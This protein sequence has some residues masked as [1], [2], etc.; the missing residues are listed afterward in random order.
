MGRSGDC[1][2]FTGIMNDTC[3]AGV[4]YRELVGPPETGWAARL[5]C[6]PNSSL[7]KPPLVECGKFDPMTAEE[8]RAEKKEF[9]ERFDL[10]SR[11]ITAIKKLGTAS[12]T[13]VCPKCGENLNFSVAKSNGH[14]WGLCTTTGCL[15]RMM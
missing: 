1:R 9:K 10:I 11:T 8:E 6:L 5:P 4:N 2:R 12:G 14:I 15:T 13:I 7:R 3:K